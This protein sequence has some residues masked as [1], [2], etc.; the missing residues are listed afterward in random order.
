MGLMD[1]HFQISSKIANKVSLYRLERP[2]NS[3]SVPQLVSTI[4]KT[5]G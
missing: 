5:I 3:F 2:E 1:W 4:L